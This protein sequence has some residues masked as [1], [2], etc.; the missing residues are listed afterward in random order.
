MTLRKPRKPEL[1]F[2]VTHTNRLS[3]AAKLAAMPALMDFMDSVR[4]D[5]EAG[6]WVSADRGPAKEVGASAA[7]TELAPGGEG[8]ATSGEELAPT[9]VAQPAFRT[10]LPSGYPYTVGQV[11]NARKA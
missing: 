8:L 3:E 9:Y 7:H 10:S 5:A 4:W 11:S 1:V 6:C 2:T